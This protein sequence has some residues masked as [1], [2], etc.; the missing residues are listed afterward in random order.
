MVKLAMKMLKHS[1]VQLLVH[2]QVD[3]T[4]KLYETSLLTF[5]QSNVR[6]LDQYNCGQEKYF[7]C[8]QYEYG[9]DLKFVFRLILLHEF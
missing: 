2:A 3:I 1:L 6:F 4:G 5:S 7:E 8:I 9:I